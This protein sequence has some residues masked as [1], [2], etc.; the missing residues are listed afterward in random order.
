MWKQLLLGRPLTLKQQSAQTVTKK[1]ALALLS[2]DAL[3]SVAYGPEQI[4]IL[5]FAAGAMNALFALPITVLIVALLLLLVIAY[6]KVI[7]LFPEGGGAYKVARTVIGEKAA[8]MSAVL[9]LLDY[10]LTI[11]VSVSARCRCVHCRISCL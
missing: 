10:I 11:A 7:V 8:L 1:E 4:F 6:R 2:S 5:L 3:S 9:L